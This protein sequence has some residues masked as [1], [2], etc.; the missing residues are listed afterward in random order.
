MLQT[1]LTLVRAM[2]RKVRPASAFGERL[3]KLRTERGITRAQLAQKIGSSQRAISAHEILG[4]KPPPKDR[5]TPRGP[6]A[7]EELPARPP[8]T[9]DEPTSRHPTRQLAGGK[10]DGTKRE[11]VIPPWLL[12]SEPPRNA[13]CPR[14]DVGR[15]SRVK[16]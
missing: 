16:E 5:Q 11:D 7:L 3:T 1:A 12:I 9:R 10:K 13:R 8:A 6:P 4:L 15:S 2:P 14:Q